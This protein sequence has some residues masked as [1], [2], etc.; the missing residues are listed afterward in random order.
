MTYGTS[1]N[2][3]LGAGGLENVVVA[4]TLNGVTSLS[5]GGLTY[6]LGSATPKPQ[7]TAI[8]IGNSIAA[9]AKI[10]STYWLTASEV[11][12]ADIL[13][14]APLRW[15]RMTATIRM[16]LYGAYGYSGQ[17]L[18]TILADLPAQVWGQ[19]RTSGVVPDIIIAPALL[20]NDIAAGA[21]V[22]AMQASLSQFIRDAQGRY[23]GAVLLLATP[24]VSF[25]YDTAAKVL[26]YQQIRDHMLTLDDAHSIFVS[27]IDGYENP[28]SPGTPLGT[29][30]SP[31]YTDSTVHPNAKG[32][33]VNAR[34]IAATLRRISSKWKTTYPVNSTN[35]AMD[36]TGAA[37]GTN[38][39]GTV[40]T[41]VTVSGSANATSIV[42]TAEQPGLLMAITVAAGTAP[43]PIDVS[44]FNFG[45]LAI[46]GAEISPFVEIELVSGAENLHNIELMVRDVTTANWIYYVQNQSNH[47]QPD[48]I[49]GDVLTL[50]MPTALVAS[51]TTG[52]A[53]VYI[54]PLPKYQG[55]TTIFRIRAQGIGL[56]S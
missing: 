26:A 28:D 13:A 31:I 18:P 21:T 50:R 24:H 15:K 36:G 56:V 29:S 39:S 16:D 23:S 35:M 42:C 20:E 17:T 22:A 54:K 34:V 32:A 30:G 55:G 9:Q 49:N 33:V 12:Q 48:W 53:A 37:S 38:V 8:V 40:P 43:N 47:L 7:M 2:D 19:L 27:R 6:G 45:T 5:A 25:S 46:S 3:D 10:Q 52:N 14:G 44:T 41:S 51:I 11:H 1:I 4:S